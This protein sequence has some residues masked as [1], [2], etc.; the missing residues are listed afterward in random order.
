MCLT[1][2]N[3]I[4]LLIYGLDLFNQTGT[5]KLRHKKKFDKSM[6]LPKDINKE[7]NADPQRIRENTESDH[8]VESF[9]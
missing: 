3:S 5:V 4:T 8:Q 9:L 2:V 6:E 1:E 7:G